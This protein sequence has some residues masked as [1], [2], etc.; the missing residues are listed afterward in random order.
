M[1]AAQQR[2]YDPVA[3][4]FLSVDPVVSDPQSGVGFNRFVYALNR[5]LNLTDPTGLV[6]G[7]PFATPE[8]AAR[9]ALDSANPKSIAENKEYGGVIYK[10]GD[11]YYA[12]LPVSGKGDAVQVASATVAKSD[13]KG[14]YHT[15]GDYSKPDSSGNPKRTEKKY[16]KYNS[17]HFSRQDK[18][19]IK[20]LSEGRVGY[21]GYLGTPGGA[22]LKYDAI[23][24][25][26]SV[27]KR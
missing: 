10:N 24:Q 5:P 1:C 15:H 17:D 14:A 13:E 7:D 6:P 18:E 9:D 8:E 2:Y 23:S 20:N 25:I 11:S 4:R 3:G 22:Y 27:L 19:N 26:E 16:D 21:K 12:S